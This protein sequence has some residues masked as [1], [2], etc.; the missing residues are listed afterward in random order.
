M[1]PKVGCQT[2]STKWFPR[3]VFFQLFQHVQFSL[4]TVYQPLRIEGYS[5]RGL[6]LS[7]TSRPILS[8]IYKEPTFIVPGRSDHIATGKVGSGITHGC[9]NSLHLFF[10]AL[11]I[12][13]EDLD[14]RLL[15]QGIP[16]NAWSERD[17]IH[18]QLVSLTK[19]QLQRFL[20]ELE[21][22]ASYYGM[23][24]NTT[25]NELLTRPDRTTTI[26][27]SNSNL[28]LTTESAKSFRTMV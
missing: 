22:E 28:G 13:F 11:S 4:F 26:H 14:N 24:L 27:F 2:F 12:I 7:P 19:S 17:A 3:V 23:S 1:L 25:K 6:P 5:Y 16:T 20:H 9:P 15:G 10:I 18:D 8:S 21:E